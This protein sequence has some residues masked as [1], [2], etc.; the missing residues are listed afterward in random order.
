MR[1]GVRRLFSIAHVSVDV[2]VPKGACA[3]SSC[4]VE[5][6]SHV[7]SPCNH[8]FQ[9]VEIALEETGH[10]PTKMNLAPLVTVMCLIR[11]VTLST[12]ATD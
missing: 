11:E 6:T 1:E 7:T 4:G 5:E 12:P 9:V 3:I 8:L 10:F 2:C